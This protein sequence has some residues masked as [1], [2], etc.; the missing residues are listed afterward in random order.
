MHDVVWGSPFCAFVREP[1]DAL[2]HSTIFFLFI[3]NVII[4]HCHGVAV[5]FAMRTV[6]GTH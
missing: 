3:V 5:Y 2:R 4:I 6:I 1:N